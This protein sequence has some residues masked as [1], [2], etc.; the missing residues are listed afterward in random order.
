MALPVLH[1]LDDDTLG[2]K[3]PPEQLQPCRLTCEDVFSQAAR[4][5]RRT[6][7][8][9]ATFGTHAIDSDGVLQRG[10]VAFW[11]VRVILVPMSSLCIRRARWISSKSLV[12]GRVAGFS[13]DNLELPWYLKR[14]NRCRVLEILSAVTPVPSATSLTLS[15]TPSC[16]AATTI[17]VAARV[18]GLPAR[19]LRRS[20]ARCCTFQ[21]SPS[22]EHNAAT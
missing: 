5:L 17:A 6:V 11:A 13:H 22:W 8:R 2:R 14:Q 19:P 1:V 4:R 12:S 10:S 20:F 7:H 18:L 3:L 16:S 15:G 9:A 21:S